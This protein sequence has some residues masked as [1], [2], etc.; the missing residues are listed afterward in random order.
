MVRKV[1]LCSGEW[2][3]TPLQEASARTECLIV[4]KKDSERED[5]YVKLLL[6]GGL[7]ANFLE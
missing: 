7:S 2:K 3:L 5:K 1:P 4:K 6:V